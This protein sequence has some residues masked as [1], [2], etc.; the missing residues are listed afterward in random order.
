MGDVDGS[1]EINMDDAALLIRYCNNLITLTD[2]QKAISDLDGNGEINMD[3]A[4]LLI[5]YCNN[6][7]EKFPAQN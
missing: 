2:E 5:R 4:A 7:L 6:L 1:G 3:D